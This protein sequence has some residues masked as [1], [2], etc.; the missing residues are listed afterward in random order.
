[1]LS[2]VYCRAALVG[3]GLLWLACLP[4]AQALSTLAENEQLFHMDSGQPVTPSDVLRAVSHADVSVWGE[5]H[6]N[7]RHHALRA[8]LMRA[9][10]TRGITV[11][12]EH[13]DAGKQVD[14]RLALPDALVLA[15]FD[16]SAWQWPVHQEL[17][18]AV[19][20]SGLVLY[21]GNVPASQT[22][23]VYKSLG[24]SM[25]AEIQELLRQANLDDA[26]MQSLREEIDKGH[27]HALPA[28]MFDAMIAVQRARDAS[29]ASVLLQHMPSVLLAGN[30][31]AWKHLGVPQ[32]IR[33]HQPGLQVVSLLFIEHGLFSSPADRDD[34]LRYWQGKADFIWVTAPRARKDPCA[35]FQKK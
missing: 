2:S 24:S 21:G 26:S 22:R 15:G 31:H 16:A 5:V 20:Q 28:H 3:A 25:P 4:N 33:A 1:M 10:G 14:T 9:I 30:G 29:M 8:D 17:F 6:D 27:C 34:W 23:E 35:Q 12:A 13:M 32:I 7:P 18:E 19:Q 11:V